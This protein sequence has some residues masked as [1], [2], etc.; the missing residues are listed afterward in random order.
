MYFIKI[1]PPVSS[2]CDADVLKFTI[3]F[4]YFVENDTK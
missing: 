1:A 2:Y 4:V 3:F